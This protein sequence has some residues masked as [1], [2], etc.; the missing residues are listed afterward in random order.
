MDK[1][2]ELVTPR[3]SPLWQGALHF[4][5]FGPLGPFATTSCVRARSSG[6]AAKPLWAGMS[7]AAHDPGCW[8]GPGSFDLLLRSGLGFRF[9]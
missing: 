5:V 7:A 8:E 1:T 2:T 3:R 9:C 6:A 4:F